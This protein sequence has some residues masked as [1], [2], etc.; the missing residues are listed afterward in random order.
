MVTRDASGLRGGSG[1]LDA[2]GRPRPRALRD[3]GG[4]RPSRRHAGRPGSR[5]GTAST[6]ARRRPA[7]RGGLPAPSGGGSACSSPSGRSASR[8]GRSRPTQ[9]R[10]GHQPRQPHVLHRVHLLHDRLLPGVLRDRAA[11][12]RRSAWHTRSGLRSLFRVQHHRIDWW[13][14]II[15]FAGTLWFNRTTLERARRRARGV[16]RAT[17]PC[18]VPTR[19]ARCA[20]W[21]RAGCPGPRSATG[22]SPGARRASRGGSPL[23]NLVGLRRLRRLG[24]RLLRQ[25]ERPAGQP[26]ADQPGHV[27]RR[28]LLPGRRGAPA[29]R[30]DAGQPVR[31][32]PQPT[33]PVGSVDL[34]ALAFTRRPR[35]GASRM[36]GAKAS[37]S[38]TLK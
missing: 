25:A 27:R 29:A 35:P 19:W 17:I 28:R 20:S 38:R 18:G 10:V 7:P 2:A 6:T 33:Q 22:R 12:P 36:T 4:V 34:K 8:W 1:G 37:T 24:D 15:Q 11:R 9:R 14:A 3:P 13:A 16:A 5:A 26:G 32:S 23:L 31:R 30:A 21:C